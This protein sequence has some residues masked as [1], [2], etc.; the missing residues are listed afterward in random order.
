MLRKT[1]PTKTKYKDLFPSPESRQR[2]RLM[3]DKIVRNSNDDFF[4]EESQKTVMMIDFKLR[5]IITNPTSQFYSTYS[6]QILIKLLDNSSNLGTCI[7]S[8]HF[9]FGFVHRTQHQKKE[10]LYFSI[11]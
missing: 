10:T 2:N 6:K 5:K 9:I 4:R 1:T 8:H 3:S 7:L 11:S